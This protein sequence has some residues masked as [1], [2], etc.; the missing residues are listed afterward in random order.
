MTKFNCSMQKKIESFRTRAE[1]IDDVINGNAAAVR[2]GQGRYA[3][4][5]DR[6]AQKTYDSKRYFWNYIGELIKDK[7][8][9]TAEPWDKEFRF[10]DKN[11]VYELIDVIS[12]YVPSITPENFSMGR[13]KGKVVNSDMSLYMLLDKVAKAD[14]EWQKA[15][16][17]YAGVRGVVAD[18]KRDVDFERSRTPEQKKFLSD[19]EDFKGE[20]ADVIRNALKLSVVV[21][22]YPYSHPD[23]DRFSVMVDHNSTSGT[24]KS[25]SKVVNR[26]VRKNNPVP[27]GKSVD[28][29]AAAK[30]LADLENALG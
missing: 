5:Q 13:T 7:Y 4:A 23:E 12:K 1:G 22:Y 17:S 9:I 14:P 6:M 10:T 28:L 15:I 29:D 30:T 3:D 25:I 11:K 21:T 24:S 19:L 27:G 18:L 16:N 26:L 20:L 2:G 8:G